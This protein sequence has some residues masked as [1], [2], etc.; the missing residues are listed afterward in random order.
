MDYEQPL[1]SP[2]VTS[3]RAAALSLAL[4]LAGGGCRVEATVETLVEGRSG[5]VRARFEL[6]RDAVEALGGDLAEG[7]QVDDLRRAGWAFAGPRRTRGGGAVVEVSK[8]YGEPADLGPVVAELSGPGGPLRDFALT[9]SASF[10]R[11]RYRLRGLVDLGGGGITG[12]P[13]APDLARRLQGAGVDPARLEEQ[14]RSRAQEG[15]SFRLKVGLPGEG[16][17]E[18]TRQVRP[19]QRVE[20]RATSSAIAPLRPALLGLAVLSALGA[21]GMAIRGRRLR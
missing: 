10:G 18:G 2:F 9:R 11:T 5:V 13:N 7:A 6:D 17:G 3:G 14:L 19:G 1:G 20:V 21:A 16:R 12:F 4:L 15:L 8:R